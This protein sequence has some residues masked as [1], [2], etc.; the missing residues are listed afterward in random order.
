MEAVLKLG[1]RRLAEL[2]RQGGRRGDPGQENCVHAEEMIVHVRCERCGETKDCAVHTRREV[3]LC[4]VCLGMIV[5]E[6]RIRQQDFALL[7][8]S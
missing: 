3:S 4:A 1:K 8:A 5:L 7:T 2:A 6:W